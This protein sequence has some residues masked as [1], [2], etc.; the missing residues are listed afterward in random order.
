MSLFFPKPEFYTTY[1]SPDEIT[2]R[3]AETMDVNK[4]IFDFR[5]QTTRHLYRQV[6]GNG[7]RF[8]RGRG[9]GRSAMAMMKEAELPNGQGT[10]IEL[11]VT[12]PY[13]FDSFSIVWF[14]IIILGLQA[15][16]FLSVALFLPIA[17]SERFFPLLPI[18]FFALV[19]GFNCLYYESGRK[20]LRAHLVELFQL[21]PLGAPELEI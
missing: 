6:A 16:I 15:M 3:V 18:P 13:V 17:P 4:P 8:Y 5:F 20:K 10:A 7:W 21:R 11:K 19:V 2:G 14:L 1:L 9:K 12:A